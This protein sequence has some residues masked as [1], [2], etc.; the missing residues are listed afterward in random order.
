MFDLETTSALAKLYTKLH[1]LH[2][3]LE[4][5]KVEKLVFTDKEKYDILISEKSLEIVD[6]ISEI[7]RHN[8]FGGYYGKS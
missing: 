3:Q 2:V 5:L 4:R 8:I 7:M 1:S 6:V